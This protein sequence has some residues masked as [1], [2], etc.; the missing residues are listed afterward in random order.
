MSDKTSMDNIYLFEKIKDCQT[1]PNE[2]ANMLAG[3]TKKQFKFLKDKES[4]VK[5]VEKSYKRT[6]KKYLKF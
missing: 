5:I 6:P 4:S 2:V 1:T 3:L